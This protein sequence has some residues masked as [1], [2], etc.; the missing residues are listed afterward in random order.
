MALLN[1]KDEEDTPT[2]AEEGNKAVEAK[3][4]EDVATIENTT[5]GNTTTE[6]AMIEDTTAKDDT[7]EEHK[8]DIVNTDEEQSDAVDVEMKESSP[9][10]EDPVNQ[11][12][13]STSDADIESDFTH[14]NTA[15]FPPP[16]S[17]PPAYEDIASSSNQVPPQEEKKPLEPFKPNKRPSVDTMMFGKQQDVTGKGCSYEAIAAHN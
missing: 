9:V 16:K 13:K 8:M 4:E 10:P 2:N 14:A 15:I 7:A 6:D 5:A 12:N 17:P 3:K 11:G 1:V